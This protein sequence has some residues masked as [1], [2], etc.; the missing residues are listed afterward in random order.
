MSDTDQNQDLHEPAGPTETDNWLRCPTYWHLDR[1]WEPVGPWKPNLA[2]G[3]SIGVGL[4]HLLQQA[5]DRAEL[6]ALSVLEA[7]FIENDEWTLEA[8][9]A[10]VT[11]SIREAAKTTI[12][13]IL[14]TE[15]V[16]QTEL[17]IGKGRLDLVTKRGDLLI[18]TDHKTRLQLKSEWVQKE[19]L[20][21]ETNWQLWDYAYRAREYYQ[22]RNVAVRRHLGVL[23]P[24]MKWHLHGEIQIKPELLDRWANGARNVWFDLNRQKVEPSDLLMNLRECIGR[25]GKCPFYEACHTCNLDPERMSL[26]YTR[27][28]K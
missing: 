24:R 15:K 5:P 16:L 3:A 6:E 20:E 19:L 2:L 17:T 27:R 28:E 21:S 22:T 25:Y 9:Q 8:L 13:D 7:R 14:A 18:V 11:K 12:K 10:L 1:N 23:T 4:D 26:L